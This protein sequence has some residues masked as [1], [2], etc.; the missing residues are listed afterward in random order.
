VHPL[1]RTYA[2]TIPAGESV[3]TSP[4]RDSYDSFRPASQEPDEPART[5]HGFGACLACADLG[6]FTVAADPVAG[7][8]CATHLRSPDAVVAAPGPLAPARA[9]AA[10]SGPLSAASVPL[11]S[12]GYAP[13]TARP[14]LPAPPRRPRRRRTCDRRRWAEIP[15]FVRERLS[16]RVR[17][18]TGTFRR[19]V[20]RVDEVPAGVR[21][22]LDPAAA[23]ARFDEHPDVAAWRADRW[24]NWRAVWRA[25]TH[26][27][28]WTTG[29]I[30]TTHAQL[31]AAA[32]ELFGETVSVGTV[33]R[34]IAWG[35]NAGVLHVVEPGAS[36]AA[37]GTELNRAPTYAILA[38]LPVVDEHDQVDDDA[39][40]PS[41]VDQNAHP[42]GSRSESGTALSS[43]HRS[44]GQDRIME[45]PMRA[46]PRTP[47]EQ[48][49]AIR[50]LQ[51][52]S[53]WSDITDREAV[54]ITARWFTAGWCLAAL[55]HGIDQ[56]PDG[57]K[58]PPPPPTVAHRNRWREKA[59]R[60]GRP[61]PRHE[62]EP[63]RRRAAWL[64]WRLR[65]W[66][67]AAGGPVL[68]PVR[69]VEPGERIVRP[70]RPTAP[71]PD[72]PRPALSAAGEAA[73]AAARAAAAA[74]GR[75]RR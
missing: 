15:G 63:A 74:A 22:Q 4:R 23:L 65:H 53:G 38:P 16:R 8:L 50:W 57:H 58:W 12:P 27:I 41:P 46:V 5:G 6:H 1:T 35:K 64:C 13:G 11:G 71:A 68:P 24:H 69:A 2:A 7:S 34:V 28:D 70:A 62:A 43:T 52:I 66:L 26:R 67:D 32:G 49:T 40:A 31:A 51:S 61:R 73:R 10:D 17:R 36:A 33:R 25:L 14:T 47:A 45:W 20:I 72:T 21:V 60:V 56:T 19:R 9:G 44:N 18:P 48:L 54:K 42:P 29:A 59:D 39:A 30:T 75:R 55:V 37:L 3:R